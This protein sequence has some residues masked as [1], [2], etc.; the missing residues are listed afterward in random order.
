M[1]IIKN[2]ICFRTYINDITYT[3][4]IDKYGNYEEAYAVWGKI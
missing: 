3:F 1:N 4:F 2:S